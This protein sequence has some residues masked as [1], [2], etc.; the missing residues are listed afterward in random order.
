MNAGSYSTIR[1]NQPFS[2]KAAIDEIEEEIIALAAEVATCKKEV[3]ILKSEQD[4]VE[5]V[6]KTQCA[7]IKR[8]L[9][10][11]ISILDD[12]ISK[13]NVRQKAENSRF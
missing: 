8:Y 13:A 3:Q 2:F 4:T 12:V 11:E 6:S 10:K 1:S 7:D 9:E 5:E